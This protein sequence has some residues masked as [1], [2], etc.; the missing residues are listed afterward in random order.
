[1]LFSMNTGY[2]FL[3]NDKIRGQKKAGIVMPAFPISS[4]ECIPGAT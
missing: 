4:Q 3:T 1:M 2:I